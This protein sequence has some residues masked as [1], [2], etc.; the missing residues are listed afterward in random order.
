MFR[1]SHRPGRR[2][3][4][5]AIESET[6]NDNDAED[7]AR[8]AV[9]FE[10]IVEP[11]ILGMSLTT[12][13]LAIVLLSRKK[14]AEAKELLSKGLQELDAVYPSGHNHLLVSSLLRESL[15]CQDRYDEAEVVLRRIEPEA[16]GYYF[17][18]EKESRVYE[19][20]GR[21]E[22]AATYR[23]LARDSSPLSP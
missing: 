20:L 16:R 4:L 10:R 23:R 5:S 18:D 9:T 7:Y 13:Q 11:E 14:C 19:H 12:R 3:L 2:P 22:R 17:L 8:G 1:R 6:G 21:T 15:M